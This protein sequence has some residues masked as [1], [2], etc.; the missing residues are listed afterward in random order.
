M[1]LYLA[2][3]IFFSVIGTAFIS[4]MFGMVGGTMLMGIFLQLFPPATAM[5]M[6]G[7]SQLI[8]NSYRTWVWR[9][10]IY[11][12]VLPGYLLGALSSI[13]F[14]TALQIQ[15]ELKFIYLF[16]GL[17]PFIT[18]ILPKDKNFDITRNYMSMITGITIIT[19]QLSAGVTGGFLDQAFLSSPLDRRQQIAT[20]SLIQ[21]IA[22]LIKI[23]YFTVLL[24]NAASWQGLTWQAA[25]IMA[26]AAIAG[27]SLS[28]KP[29]QKMKQ[30]TFVWIST[31]LL[32]LTGVF[33]L[34]K[35]VI[36]FHHS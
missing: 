10:Y 36:A 12:P 33:F 35:S 15:F 32:M 14:F 3:I 7:V 22:H 31:V 8:G 11:K 28:T 6:H 26:V 20:K 13:L 30:E 23:I 25:A 34:Y 4:G 19:F 27:T 17:L 9:K 18:F 16:L 29:V 1:S 5:A 2:C 21:V 24:Q